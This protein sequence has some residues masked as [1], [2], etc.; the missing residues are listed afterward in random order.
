MGGATTFSSCA[1]GGKKIAVL[2]C[3]CDTLLAPIQPDKPNFPESHTD[4][5]LVCVCVFLCMLQTFLGS[6]DIFVCSSQ[7]QK[8]V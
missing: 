6:E 7:L 2:S 4:D 1:G 5:T 8:R 3:T